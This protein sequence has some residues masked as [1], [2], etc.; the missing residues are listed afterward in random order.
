MNCSATANGSYRLLARSQTALI[1]AESLAL[2]FAAARSYRAFRSLL[3]LK[4]MSSDSPLST[5]GLP[6]GFLAG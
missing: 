6:L 3:T 2:A 4:C 1:Q 5:G